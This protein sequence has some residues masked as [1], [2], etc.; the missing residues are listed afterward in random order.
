MEVKN[1]NLEPNPRSVDAADPNDEIYLSIKIGNGQ[2]GGNKV[3]AEGKLLAKGNLTTR[4]HIGNLNSLNQKTIEV[5]TNV[6]DVNGF[7]NRCVFTT[8]F[9]NQDNKELFSKID[10]GDAPE[11]GVAS[12]KGKYIVNFIIVLLFFC[13]LFNQQVQAQTSAKDLTFTKLE[14]PTSPGLI[15]FDETP[16][17]IEKPTTPQGLGLSLLGLGQN[18]GALEFAPF[19]L[20]DHPNLSAKAMS[21]K[22]SPILS[23]FAISIASA[24]TDTLSYLSG[25]I[26]TR[27]F[28]SYRS[29]TTELN[30][31]R[32]K[33]ED[34]LADSEFDRVDSLRK[35]YIDILEKPV[36]TIDIAAAMGG[37][38][39]TNSFD[40]LELNRWAVWMTFNCR[41]KGDDFYFTIL[42][43]YINSEKYEE[44]NIEADL[45]D[46]GSRLNYDIS[47]FT[48]SL[49]YVHRM[50]FTTD[51]LNDYRL[52]AIGSYHL[53][54]NIFL[55]ATFGKNFSDVNNIIAL[56]GINFGFSQKK[57][58]A[59]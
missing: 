19:W 17:S 55:T 16:S 46:I 7:T 5:E 58:K 34:A 21:D 31:L 9:Y 47:K 4:T 10:K 11:N 1:Y 37:S 6:L 3:T 39:T 26:R 14:T 57:V 42:S 50:N 44:T 45:V 48:V 41:P 27:I 52:A 29:D 2:L 13:C 40:D 36:F 49:E 15:L 32:T 20:V 30:N 51:I 18:G 43:R 53:A 54:E 28:Q 8:A 35:L 23:H 24:K 25:G 22:K 33:I 56:A 38:N 12:F 59:Y